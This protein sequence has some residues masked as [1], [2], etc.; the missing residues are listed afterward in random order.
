MAKIIKN[1]KFNSKYKVAII[2][3]AA[4]LIIAFYFLIEFNYSLF[5]QNFGNFLGLNTL[6]SIIVSIAFDSLIFES[7]LFFKVFSK[8]INMWF[9]LTILLMVSS[10]TI[11]IGFISDSLG[12]PSIDLVLRD[13]DMNGKVVGNITCIDS[14]GNLLVNNIVTCNFLPKLHNFTANTTFSFINDTSSAETTKDIITFIAPS[15][16]KRI[17]FDIVGF[18]GNNSLRKIGVSN[19]ATFYT[20]EENA[21][22]NEK[23]IIYFLGLLGIVAITVPSMMVNLRRLYGKD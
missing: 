22:R 1:K 10:F 20:E 4:I 9:L 12:K 14:S 15:N 5:Q 6:L 18:D 3:V 23:R 17:G 2:L 8:K 21:S 11:G 16:V 7:Y 13:S 19:D